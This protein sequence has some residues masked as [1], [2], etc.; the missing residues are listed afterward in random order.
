MG[1]MRDTVTHSWTGRTSQMPRLQLGYWEYWL[2]AGPTK[3]LTS[4]RDLKR[5]FLLVR[6]EVRLIF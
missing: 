6:K 2:T 1:K 5:P 4:P 3:Q